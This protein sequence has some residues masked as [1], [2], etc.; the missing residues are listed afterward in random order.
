V[1]SEAPKA[2]LDGDRLL[3]LA[4]EH[5]P[6]YATAKELFVALSESLGIDKTWPAWKG[7]VNRNPGIRR[8]INERLQ[9]PKVERQEPP[10]QEFDVEKFFELSLA[11]A[12]EWRKRSAANDRLSIKIDTTQ[13]IGI[14]F[15]SDWHV[16]GTGTEHLQIKADN[17]TIAAHPQLYA[18]VGGDWSNNF[19]IPA[20]A[21]AG[22]NDV[23]RP[24]DQQYEIVTYLLRILAQN[25]SILAIGDGNHDNWTRRLVNIDPRNYVLS[26]L[27]HLY[28]AQ[29]SLLELT[30]GGQLYRIFRRH[31]HRFSS[32]F[33]PGHAVVAE[34]QRNPYDFDIGVIEHQ[35]EPH[36]SGFH[37]KERADGTTWRVAVRPGTYKTS[38]AFANEFGFYNSSS[39]L[40]TVIL[41]PDR[42]WM[43]PVRGLENAIELL[44][45]L[46]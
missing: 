40:I 11:A 46:S 34:Y 2:E 19:V 39:D 21:H 10:V 41:Y 15:T 5:A 25:D 43:Q 6:K 33:N 26:G 27:A 20:L 12:D 18:Y 44:D 30:V 14:V 45:G 8:Q 29:G 9:R 17:E 37:G 36:Y 13:P 7:L 31:R 23:F 4:V 35:H 38:D 24:G 16:G 22:Q 32:V 3:A 1:N 42:F 28:T